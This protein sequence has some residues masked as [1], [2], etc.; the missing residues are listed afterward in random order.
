MSGARRWSSTTPVRGGCSERLLESGRRDCRFPREAT[1]S[2]APRYLSRSGDSR[3]PTART[4]KPV[5]LVAGGAAHRNR[6]PL[7]RRR[8]QNARAISRREREDAGTSQP[9]SSV[10]PP[11]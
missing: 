1:V 4:P 8:S 6:T 11:L 3:D 9:L 2:A 10:P 5:L 7:E